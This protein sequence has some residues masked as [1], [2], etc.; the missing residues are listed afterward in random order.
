M[1]GRLLVWFRTPNSK[2]A[3]FGSTININNKLNTTVGSKSKGWGRK[4][5]GP[6]TAFVKKTDR[7]DEELLWMHKHAMTGRLDQFDEQRLHSLLKK[8]KNEEC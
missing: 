4:S 8:K 1:E 6:F 3:K 7:T 5:L 2:N